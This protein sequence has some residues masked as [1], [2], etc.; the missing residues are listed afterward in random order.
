[1]ILLWI[2]CSE[3]LHWMD[4]N[5]LRS[6]YKASMSITSGCYALLLVGLGIMQQKQYLRIMAIILFGVILVKLFIYDISSMNKLTKT[7]VFI[8]LGGLLLFISYLYNKF[9][10]KTEKVTEEDLP[11]E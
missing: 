8:C 9:K 3:I 1:M 10:S 4:I 6:A 5:G 11:L 7:I 2:L